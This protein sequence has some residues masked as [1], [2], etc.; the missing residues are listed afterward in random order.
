[1]GNKLLEKVSNPHILNGL[2]IS[3]HENFFE[4]EPKPQTRSDNNGD[5][6]KL[7]NVPPGLRLSAIQPNVAVS[8]V[9]YPA[10]I[11]ILAPAMLVLPLVA[12]QYTPAP[13]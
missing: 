10:A 3:A 13:S 1:M 8:Q 7:M 5:D 6:D 12:G 11:G 2:I 4:Q 9:R